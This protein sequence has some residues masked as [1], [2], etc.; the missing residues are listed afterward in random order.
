MNS[1]SGHDEDWNLHPG[2]A[3]VGNPLTVNDG[4]K[5]LPKS[6]SKAAAQAGRNKSRA[7]PLTSFLICRHAENCW[8]GSTEM[9]GVGSETLLCMLFSL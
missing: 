6:H 3:A 8:F 4:I 7:E 2:V 1:A 5:Q 9:Q